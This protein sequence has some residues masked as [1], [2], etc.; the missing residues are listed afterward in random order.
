[1]DPRSQPV[2]YSAPNRRGSRRLGRGRLD[3]PPELT[4]V[5]AD[6][7]YNAYTAIEVGR[8]IEPFDI[9]WVEEPCLPE[10]IRG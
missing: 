7:A 5:V 4:K 9:A 10:D 8:G 6:H 2:P 1:M 3:R